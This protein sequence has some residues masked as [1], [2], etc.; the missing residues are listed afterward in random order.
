M[1]SFRIEKDFLGEIKINQT[2]LWGINTAR[3]AINFSISSHKI[4]ED[5]INAYAKVKLACAKTNQI[6]GFLDNKIAEKICLAAQELSD[7][8]LNEHIIVDAYQ[9]G[10][11]TS[12]NLNICEVIANR[13]LILMGKKC[14]EYEFCD[15]ILHVNMHQSTNDTYPTA[16]K[17]A[18]YAKL[19]QL[20]NTIINLQETF[21]QKEKEFAGIV[22]IARTELMDAIPMTFGMTFSAWSDV[23]SR[24]RWRI[25]KALEKIRVINLGGTAIGTGLCAPREYIF[26]VNEEIKTI[27]GFPLARAEN[28]VDATQNLDSFME[29]MGIIKIHAINMM[30]I[31]NDLRLMN[32]GPDAGIGE[33]E[34]PALQVGSSIMPDKINPVIPEMLIQVAMQISGFENSLC[35]AIGQGQLELNSFLPLVA[36]NLLESLEIMINAE[37]IA[38]EKCF[39]A[40]KINQKKCDENVMKSRVMTTILIPFIG[41]YKA[42]EIAKLMKT[43]NLSF[44]TAAMKITGFTENKL[45]NIIKPQAINALGF[46][47]EMIS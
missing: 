46:T 17:I 12:T 32:M 28:M 20:E 13:A 31:S 47:K 23:L 15:P 11:G 33:I 42:S 8:L 9:G 22:K 10:A 26:K 1:N 29:T 39:K 45:D 3:A 34:L 4:P 30:K 21:Q 19:K 27:T 43:N 41:Y 18:V 35:W 7:G 36:Y 37:N 2:D 6:L 5:L 40:I 38:C 16:L 24:D 14:G 25:Y 44:K